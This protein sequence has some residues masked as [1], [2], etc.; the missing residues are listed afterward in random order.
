MGCT[1]CGC[2]RMH[3]KAR[4]HSQCGERV[5]AITGTDYTEYDAP[6]S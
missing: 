4:H 2:D 5:Y 6:L 1:K 3:P